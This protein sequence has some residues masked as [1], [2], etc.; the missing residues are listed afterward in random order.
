MPQV[1]VRCTID[2]CYFWHDGSV[3][4]ANEILVTSDEVGARYPQDV[5]VQQLSVILEDV[6]QTP[7]DACQETCCKTF[8]PWH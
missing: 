6:G 4:G 8:R 7:A 3:C 5:D 1:N 2:N